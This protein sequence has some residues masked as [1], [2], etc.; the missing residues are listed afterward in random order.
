MP[1]FTR[2][3]DIPQYQ[4]DNFP[5]PDAL[6]YKYDGHWRKYSS[7]DV[8]DT[9]N[10]MSAGF[11]KMGVKKG[12][13]IGL[14]ST[15]RPE[16]NFIDLGVLQ[17]GAINVPVYPTI[18]REEYIYI[19]NDA[20]I[21]YC[22][23]EDQGLLD[24][25]KDIF[26]EVPS[27]EEIFTIEE[28]DGY[29]HWSVVQN[30]G[31]EEGDLKAVEEAKNNVDKMDLASLIY[32][33]GT[34][35]QPKGVMLCHNN[36]V[37]NI[38]SVYE[39]LPMNTSQ[40][41]LSFLPLC[42]IFERTVSYTYM[43]KGTAIWYAESIDKLG[44]NL[45]EVKPHYFST[46]PRLL[47]KVYEK[48]M[49]KGEEQTG[50]KRK[51]FFWAVELG[52]KYDFHDRSPIYNMKLAVARKLIFS[53]WIEAMG[54][55]VIGIVTGA[56]KLPEYLARLFNAAGVKVREGYGMTESSPVITMNQF[57]EAKAYMGSVG[58]VIPN[59]EVK[60]AEDGEVCAKGD[61]VMMGYYNKPEATAETIDED[62]WLHTGDIGT[63]IEK[64]GKKFLKITD[65]KKSLFKTSGGKYVAPQVIESKYKESTFIDQIVVLGNDRKFVSALIVPAFPK[66]EEHCKSCGINYNSPKELVEHPEVVKIYENIQKEMNPNFSKVEQVKRFK[67]M[68]EEWT[69][70]GK[71]LTAT[72]KLRRKVIADKYQNEI[73]D[74]YNV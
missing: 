11:L 44:D 53:K 68:P 2:L 7:K 25:V 24:K 49:A 4:L 55:D 58:L 66:L 45:R 20:Q 16:W 21:K 46:V 65:R 9:A 41:A 35:G 52:L 8:I 30:I 6:A 39:L 38:K 62:G 37:A 73:E 14:I 60:I 1:N 63:W 56:A 43:S 50:I 72:M 3:F 26:E 48:I 47:E 67:L 19:F 36:I 61:N 29:R 34:T 12:D 23:V 59:V 17:I 31:E 51:L 74:I 13:K 22:F 57:D 70:E 69:I 28:I 27:L 54:G 32:T 42:H 15:N 18:S 10:S 33:S 40:K 71:E 64:G 5:R